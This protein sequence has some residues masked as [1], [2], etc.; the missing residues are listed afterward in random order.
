MN[1]VYVSSEELNSTAA[2][3]GVLKEEMNGLF[4]QMKSL[5]HQMSSFWDSP[6][7]RSCI[8]QFDSLSPVFP[9]YVALVDN[10]CLFLRQTAQAYRVEEEGYK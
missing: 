10:Y 6:A 7:A 5:I 2:S 3:V 1:Q 4:A 9:Q 8:A